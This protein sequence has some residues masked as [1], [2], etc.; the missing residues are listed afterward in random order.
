MKAKKTLSLLLTAMALAACSDHDNGYT[1]E[2]ISYIQNYKDVFGTVDTSNDWNA[3][4]QGSVTVTTAQSTRVKVYANTFGTYNLVADYEGVAGTQALS[5]DMLE[6]TEYLIVSDGS[7]AVAVSPGSSVSLTAQAKTR[8]VNTSTANGL[9]QAGVT[10]DAQATDFDPAYIDKVMEV[11]PEEELNLDRVSQNFSYVST[12]TF[13]LYPIYMQTS[14]RHRLGIYWKDAAGQYRTQ[15]VYNDAEGDEMGATTNWIEGGT[16]AHAK[17]IH[18]SL[19]AGTQFG[20]YLDVYDESGTYRHTVYSQAEM[21]QY[22]AHY[23]L[24]GKQPT[25]DW[26]GYNNTGTWKAADAPG[27][28][29]FGATFRANLTLSNGTTVTD[30]QFL[31][32]E[33]WNLWGPDL[34]DLVFAFKGDNIP[35]ILDDDATSWVISA[36]DLGGTFDIDYNDVVVAVNHVGGQTTA[37]VTPLAAGGTLASFLFFGDKTE[38]NCL[39]EIHELFGASRVTSGDY[40]PVNVGSTSPTQLG[41]AITISVPADFTLASYTSQD[42]SSTSATMGGFKVV[43]IPKGEAPSVAAAITSTA[44][45][46]IQNTL[47]KNDDNVPYVI[48]TPMRWKRDNGDGTITT[49]NYR[50]PMEYVPMFP[51]AERNNP[52]YNHNDQYSFR[53][54]IQGLNKETSK[55]WYLYPEQAVTCATGTPVTITADLAP[56]PGTVN[57]KPT[58]TTGYGTEL[59]VGYTAEMWGYYPPSFPVSA[60][61]TSGSVTITFV[62]SGDGWNNEGTIRGIQQ[63]EWGTASKDFSATQT[64]TSEGSGP[65]DKTTS[66]TLNAADYADCT[67]IWL[68]ISSSDG[69]TIRAFYK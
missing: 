38:E 12:G 16:T 47:T 2:Q 42:A 50:W 64:H 69:T 23:T 52:A 10:V 54:W 48:C 46:T 43:T 4:E 37:T 39:G 19:P 61:P 31:C 29:C 59:T 32:F 63:T 66:I 28:Y 55:Y 68:Q 67:Y 45:Q 5:F 1:E 35:T 26:D 6:G 21:N 30:T 33:D 15:L 56:T 40:N 11:L 9:D 51:F 44:G 8:T 49:G 34:N 24:D 14:S 3:V 57:E 22:C 53:S 36:E 17:G 13:T 25:S 65:Y 7:Q 20:F 58:D 27:I 41:E 60:L 18:I 62:I